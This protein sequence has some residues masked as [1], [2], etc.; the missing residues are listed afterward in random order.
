MTTIEPSVID[1][2]LDS[3]PSLRWQVLADL[4][5]APAG[6]VAAERARV[7]TE[8]VGAQLLALQDEE[9]YWGG[10]AWNPGWDSTMHALN[11]LYTFGLDPASEAAKNAMRKVR[12]GVHWVGW[13]QDGSWKGFDFV[14]NPYFDGEVEPCINGQVAASAVYFGEKVERIKGL[15]LNEQMEDGGWNCEQER[16]STRGSF[17]TTICV[18]EALLELERSGDP[19]ARIH[20]ER[21]R[22]EEFLL[23]RR[24]FKRL[25]TGEILHID[26]MQESL[27]TT[28][29]FPPFPHYDYLRALE[30]FRRANSTPDPR[31]SDAIA[32]L[33]SKR[34]EDGRWLLE[35]QY[36]GTMLVDLGETVGEPS[37]W[38]TLRAL[39][40]LRWYE[41]GI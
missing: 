23:A 18:L 4:L 12:E 5:D 9:G 16:G 2:L 38:N 29:S 35:N 25:S 37:R 26:R 27:F 3:D 39:R 21:L 20:A 17:N 10:T 7:E 33:R 24:L 32:L 41:A 30:Y 15:L 19:D 36:E 34:Q 11:L 31:V 28:L 6:E 40:V 13:D 1:W 8:G 14:G 22:G